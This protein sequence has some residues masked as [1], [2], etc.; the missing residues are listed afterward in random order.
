MSTF[1]IAVVVGMALWVIFAMVILIILVYGIRLLR[2]VREP[3]ARVSGAV[4]DLNERLRPVLR[5]AEQASD[6]ARQIAARLKR[7]VDDVSDAIGNATEST[8]RMVELVEERVVEV[9]AL[10]AVIQEEAEATF[11][12]TA[13]LLRGLRRGSRKVSGEKPGGRAIGDR[14]PG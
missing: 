9:A 10:V 5:N 4:T 7:D 12:S 1:E 6:Q 11:V 8:G 2:D 3:L 13:S 14:R